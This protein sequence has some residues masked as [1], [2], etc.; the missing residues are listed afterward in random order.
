MIQSVSVSLLGTPVARE[1][2]RMGLGWCTDGEELAPCISVVNFYPSWRKDTQFWNLS[3]CI[4]VLFRALKPFVILSHA[5]L[6]ITFSF[7]SNTMVV[8]KPSFFPPVLTHVNDRRQ[9]QY[10][11][12]HLSRAGVPGRC[13]TLWE[14][15]TCYLREGRSDP[16]GVRGAIWKSPSK[17]FR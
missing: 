2:Q 3:W 13:A 17:W 8:F 16:S 10:L 7:S 14:K 5:R 12:A 11:S 1:A 15:E 9:C 4:Q 6:S